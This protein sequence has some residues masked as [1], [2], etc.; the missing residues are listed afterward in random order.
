MA[1][2]Q[3]VC[4]ENRVPMLMKISGIAGLFQPTDRH[5]IPK[6]LPFALGKPDWAIEVFWSRV[7]RRLP[8]LLWVALSYGWTAK[9]EAQ[10]F[11]S[12]H[13]FVAGSTN[14]FGIYTNA[15]G[16]RPFAE[17]AL[18]GTTLFGT[19]QDGG[20]SGKGALFA[21]NLDGKAFTN[22][23]NFTPT[24]GSANINS[25]GAFPQGRLLVVN[26][27][28]YGTTV[29]GGTGG[30]GTVFAVNVDGSGIATLHSFTGLSTNGDG[31][32]PY[33]GLVLSGTTLYGTTSEGGSMGNGTLFALNT[34]GTGFKTVHSFAAS[35]T[36][37]SGFYT[38]SDGAHPWAGLLLSGNTL[39]GT[40]SEGGN[41]GKG[42]VFAIS[43]DGTGFTNLHSFTGVSEG[44][45]PYAGLVLSSNTLYGT[46]EFGGGSGHGTVFA[47]NIDG[48]GIKTLH[49]F[50]G[51]IDGARPTSVLVLSG[52]TLYGTAQFG[53]STGSGTVFAI[54]TDGASFTTLYSFNG[55]D[56]GSFPYAG[57][58]LFNNR[59]YGTATGGGLFGLGT[60]FNLPVSGAV[61]LPTLTIL[62]SGMNVVLLWPSNA[63]GFTLQST[64]NLVSPTIWMP[65]STMPAILNGQYTVTNPISAPYQF[66]RLIQ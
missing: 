39:Y 40:T 13:S 48:S 2:S 64:T 30:V 50:S 36:N 8:V 3:A 22:L 56:D 47:M 6:S 32:Y 43:T 49:N 38:N 54:T 21:I 11:S 58:V 61:N 57:L 25:D 55:G 14:A 26:N 28:L 53:G 7:W 9:L 52:N 5:L 4:I 63:T 34:D 12:L 19:A 66:F 24:S 46:T 33:A 44:A 10:P 1:W 16:T 18:S 60:V 41:A 35:R 23:H 17:L 45:Y 42:T 31:A 62:P 65:V 20:N 29:I 59:L 37:V 27:T 15:D 51:S